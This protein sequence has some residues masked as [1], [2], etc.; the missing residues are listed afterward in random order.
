MNHSD[1]AAAYRTSTFENAPPIKILRMLYE[2]ALRFLNRA[3][4]LDPQDEEF[5]KLVY[6]AD[7][8]VVELRASLD[9]GPNPELSAGLENLYVFVSGELGEAILDGKVEGV[10]NAISILSTLLEGWAQ[11]QVQLTGE[12]GHAA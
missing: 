4:T 1:A 2:G 3:L 7:D 11:A 6:R 5:R 12:A 8:I 9:H 10:E